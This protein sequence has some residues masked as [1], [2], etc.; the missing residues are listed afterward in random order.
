MNPI[1]RWLRA[2][3]VSALKSWFT[4]EWF[5][6]DAFKALRA[7]SDAAVQQMCARMASLRARDERTKTK[8]A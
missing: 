8:D 1:R 4:S 3:F 5:E 7:D 6:S 2:Q